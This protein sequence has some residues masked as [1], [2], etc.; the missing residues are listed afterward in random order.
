MSARSEPWA[1]R[2]LGIALRHVRGH[3]GAGAAVLPADLTIATLLEVGLR[4]N[5]KRAHLLVSTVLGKHLPTDPRAVLEAGDRLGDLVR[6][7]LGGA[8]ALVLGFAETA[9]GLGHIVAA[10]LDA[11]CYLH[12]TRR[13]VPEAETL[14]S[15][16]EGHSHAT[17]HLLQPAPASVF[18]GDLPLVMVD[19]EIST[20][21]TALDALRA[22][23]AFAPR[24][25]YVLASLVDMRSEADHES[26]RAVETELGVRIDTVCLVSGRTH[27]PEG[28]RERVMALPDHTLNPVAERRGTVTR[29]EL[30]WPAAV[31]EGGRHGFRDVDAGAFDA[32]VVLAAADLRDHLGAVAPGRPAIVIGHEELMYLPLRLAD[33]LRESGIP[34]RFQTTTRSPAYVLDEPGYPLRRGFGFAAPEFDPAARRYLYNARWSD[35]PE[36]GADPTHVE[37]PVLVVV[38]DAPADTA[39]LRAEGGL[40]DVLTAAGEDVVLAVVPCADPRVL[41]ADRDGVRLV[42]VGDAGMSAP[43]NPVEPR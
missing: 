16:E 20:G 19:D 27:L 21:R 6:E 33:E 41:H 38:L 34:T 15:F 32:A 4:R 23:H 18:Q 36:F 31:P 42:P 14:T 2:E 13:D 30:S 40:I 26:F 7:V 28:I 43:E 9:T 12:S 22:L 11:R 39:E 8:D 37:N 29:V 17:T 24:A 3:G 5:P 25:H 10:R 35:G 1:T